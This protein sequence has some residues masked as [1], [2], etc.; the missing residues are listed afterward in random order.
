MP[1]NRKLM[2]IRHVIE[3]IILQDIVLDK[4]PVNDGDF[5]VEVCDEGNITMAQ[6]RELS[7]RGLNVMEINGEDGLRLHI[8]VEK[9][10]AF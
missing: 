1:A 3:E 6:I 4:D 7:D 9:S 5:W 2:R 8:R 10:A